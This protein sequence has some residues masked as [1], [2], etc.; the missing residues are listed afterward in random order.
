MRCD[1]NSIFDCAG[2]C[3]TLQLMNKKRT[4]VTGPHIS[5]VICEDILMRNG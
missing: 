3:N 2:V 1:V 4:G 5:N